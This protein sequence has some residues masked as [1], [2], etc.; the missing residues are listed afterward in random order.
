MGSLGRVDALLSLLGS[1][2]LS[3]TGGPGRATGTLPSSNPA[4]MPQPLLVPA[5]HRT[6]LDSE[7]PQRANT[8]MRIFCLPF[9]DLLTNEPR[10]KKQKGRIVRSSITPVW[11]WL[12][13]QLIPE[14]LN[15]FSLSVKTAALGLRDGDMQMGAAAFW[16][17]AADALRNKLSTESGRK[18][19]RHLLGDEGVIADA[20][21][22]ALLL[23]A[24]PEICE[25]QD[26]L[27]H[28]IAALDDDVTRVFRQTEDRVR[29]RVPQALDYLP[30]V[31]LR[32]L[33]QPW[34]VLRLLESS[35]AA[36]GGV[37]VAEDV[38]FSVIERHG[39]VVL[40]SGSGPFHVDALLA[41]LE[42]FAVLSN[43][44]VQEIELRR[45]GVWGQRL[46]KLGAGVTEVVRDLLE[47]APG[48]ISAALPLIPSDGGSQVP[49]IS[50]PVPPDKTDR[51]LRY[52]RLVSGCRALAST[53]SF[54]PSARQVQETILS[55]LHERREAIRHPIED[56]DAERRANGEQYLGLIEEI[57]KILSGPAPDGQGVAVENADQTVPAER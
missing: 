55:A 24:G 44:A 9:E 4:G 33:E 21:E 17:A 29:E 34:E 8:P 30:L 56:T 36:T 38:L 47:R 48:E 28:H 32:R 1:R 45:D 25:L 22:M 18:S 49:D 19:A 2:G 50:A 20:Q 27:P 42:R 7:R 11:N 51:A 46:V 43:G 6:L 54:G 13:Q 10:Q 23:S 3:A 57:S 37:R 35:D 15:T 52:A 39:A 40:A 41:H 31:I 5:L 16:M 12:G 26:S 14:G 53:G